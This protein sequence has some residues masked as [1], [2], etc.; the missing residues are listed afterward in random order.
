[1]CVF[2]FFFQAED[3]IRDL[4]RSRGLGDVYKRQILNQGSKIR[5]ADLHPQVRAFH[6]AAMIAAGATR[7][8][9]HLIDQVP[10]CLLYTSD[11]A[12]ERSSVDLGGRRIIKK[13]KKCKD[14]GW[15][16]MVDLKHKYHATRSDDNTDT[17]KQQRIE[18][19]QQRV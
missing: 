12:D 6:V 1:M 2:F 10:L 9:A 18:N 13:K 8:A 14:R 17:K 16:D 15:R 5:T 19:E 7:R 11:A 3:G 4:V